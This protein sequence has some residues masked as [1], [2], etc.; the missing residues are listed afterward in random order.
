MLAPSRIGSTEWQRSFE[1]SE[2]GGSRE[3]LMR[4]VDNEPLPFNFVQY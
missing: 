1:C 3:Y 2:C 4:I